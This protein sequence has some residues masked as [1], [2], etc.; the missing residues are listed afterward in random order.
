MKSSAAHVSKDAREPFA[1]LLERRRPVILDGAM[2][3]ELH[4]RGVDTGLPLWSAHALLSSP[5]TVRRIHREYLGAGADIITS[6]TFR[7]TRRT[8]LRAGLPD[9]S[10]E[11]T[12]LAVALAA[13]AIAERE[14]ERALLAGSM[15]PLEDC[16]RPE[17]VPPEEI[18]RQE[19]AEQ[20]GRLAEAGVD[21]LLLETMGTVRE[22]AAAA[23]A[24]QATGLEYVVSFLCRPDGSLYGGEPLSEAVCQVAGRSPAALSLNCISPRSMKRPLSN[25]LSALRTVP[26]A[27]QLPVGLYANVGAPGEEHG[28]VFRR[29][30]GPEAYARLAGTWVKSGVSF[31]GGCC[32]TTPEYIRALAEAFA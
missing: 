8:F 12:S 29:D 22:A 20:A 1:R 9:R 7:T 17:L 32:G 18:L 3:T 24:A 19:H 5:E 15:A 2:G 16:Y 26:G 6:N 10:A 11:L 14:G 30:V 25:L 13:D 27:G 21:F 31:I 4:R 28:T 23:G